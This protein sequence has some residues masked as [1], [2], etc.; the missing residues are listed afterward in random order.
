[1]SAASD[2]RP[3]RGRIFSS[4]TETIGDTPLVRLDRLTFGTE[5]MPMP[6][7]LFVDGAGLPG[8]IAGL[9]RTCSDRGPPPLWGRSVRPTR[10]S[11]AG[12]ETS[13][14]GDCLHK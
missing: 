14:L 8:G 2:R 12:G 11:R 3:G 1:M 10:T 5:G 9:G 13:G 4:I 7:W 6:R